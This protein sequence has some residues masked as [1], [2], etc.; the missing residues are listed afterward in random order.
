MIKDKVFEDCALYGPSCIAF[1]TN[2]P[3]TMEHCKVMGSPDSVFIEI[4]GER[5]VA[6]VIGF[7]GCKFLRCQFNGIGFVGTPDV[8]AHLRKGFGG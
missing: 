2:S 3:M 4:K 1:S 5:Y 7:E 6:G 8:I